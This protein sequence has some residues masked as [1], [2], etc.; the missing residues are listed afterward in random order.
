MRIK[1]HT[2]VLGHALLEDAEVRGQ[3]LRLVPVGSRVQL[4]HNTLQLLREANAELDGI[5]DLIQ[6]V[7]L[8]EPILDGIEELVGGVDLETIVGETDESEPIGAVSVD[9]EPAASLM[10]VLCV[11]E[12]TSTVRLQLRQEA[13]DDRLEIARVNRVLRQYLVPPRYQRVQ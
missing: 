8:E 1:Q 3:V 5:F 6:G 12:A 10:S 13:D 9:L 4:V 2:Q 11:L 7:L